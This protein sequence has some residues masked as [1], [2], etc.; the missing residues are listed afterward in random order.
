M[1][2]L[3]CIKIKR[4]AQSCTR[5]MSWPEVWIQAVQCWCWRSHPSQSCSNF[6][7]Q[8]HSWTWWLNC[9]SGVH[10]LSSLWTWV[11]LIPHPQYPTSSAWV[12]A[13]WTWNQCHLAWPVSQYDH[14]QHTHFVFL[15]LNISTGTRKMFYQIHVEKESF[16]HRGRKQ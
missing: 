11:L 6:C 9:T 14:P 1:R 8:D 3:S 10:P 12:L 16:S 5:R 4:C 7:P 13:P 2:K 15:L